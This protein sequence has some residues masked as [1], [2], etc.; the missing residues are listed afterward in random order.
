MLVTLNSHSILRGYS[1]NEFPRFSARNQQLL[2]L[3]Y[4]ILLQ[5]IQPSTT[6]LY[7]IIIL[8]F[9]GITSSVKL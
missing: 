4:G 7:K 6:L 8:N 1:S 5:L 2:I 3:L 9:S